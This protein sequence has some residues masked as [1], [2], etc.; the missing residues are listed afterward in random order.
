MV[1][2][3]VETKFN[4]MHLVPIMTKAQ[5]ATAAD[6]IVYD[7]EKGVIPLQGIGQ[8]IA[9]S[10]ADTFTWGT[11]TITPTA[12]ATETSIAVTLGTVI[13][14]PP[15]YVL[16]AGGEI[17]EVVSETAPTNANSTWTVRRGCLGTT[18]T[19]VGVAATNLVAVM[20]IVFLGANNVGPDLIV[21]LPLPKDAGVRMFA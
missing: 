12:S 1:A 16:T 10:L 3:Q 15:Y 20:N 14:T 17:M 9:V 19:T 4:V 11:A 2:E 6:W 7:G 21:A 5:R 8:S 13:R 18:A